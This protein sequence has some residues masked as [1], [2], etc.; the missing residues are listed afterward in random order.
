MY[1]IVYYIEEEVDGIEINI[2]AASLL[3]HHF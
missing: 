1:I 3:C 2:S